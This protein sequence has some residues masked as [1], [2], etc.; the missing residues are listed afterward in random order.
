M[1]CQPIKQLPCEVNNIFSEYNRFLSFS[2]VH[3]A[4]RA[5]K[6]LGAAGIKVVAMPTPREIVISCGQGL[7]FMAANQAT[8]L[9]ILQDGQVAWSK[10]FKRQSGSYEEIADF[11]ARNG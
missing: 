11:T 6:L 8:V 2:S 3:H 9:A 10:L 5:E 4:I 7:L 1:K